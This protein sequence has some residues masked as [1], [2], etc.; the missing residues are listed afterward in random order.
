MVSKPEEQQ[1]LVE[2]VKE[3]GSIDEETVCQQEDEHAEP[4]EEVENVPT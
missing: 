2:Q 3:S 1:Q 4:C